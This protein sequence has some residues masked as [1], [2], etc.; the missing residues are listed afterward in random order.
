MPDVD[1]ALVD[2]EA[3]AQVGRAIEAI[4][5]LRGWRES[6]DV[7]PGV[8]IPAV[9]QA[10]G[11]EATAAL[12]ARMARF[13]WAS[14]GDG[15]EAAA[16]VSIPGGAVGVLPAEGVDLGAASRKRDA[17]RARLEQEI[18]RAEGKLS[19][20]GF[21]AKAPADVVEA[22]RGKLERLRAELAAL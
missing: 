21:V 1:P 22:E 15:G 11:Y 9:L 5:A 19:N 20:Q 14:N 8:E 4:R 12:I 16:S 3:E 17:E 10:D 7:R 2:E 13:A 6:V 18:K